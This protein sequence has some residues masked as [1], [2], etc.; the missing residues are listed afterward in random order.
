MRT[1]PSLA[2]GLALGLIS[3]SSACSRG[4]TPAECQEILDRYV[5]LTIDGDETLK[6][7]PEETRGAARE[8]KKAAKRTS[9]EFMRAR[10]QC[11]EEARSNQVQCALKAGNANEWEACVD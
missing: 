5:D 3:A 10:T 6:A 7:I 9:P 8:L 2:F 1:L 11:E 4:A